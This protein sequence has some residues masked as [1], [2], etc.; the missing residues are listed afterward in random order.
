[1]FNRIDLHALA[2]MQGPERAFL[3]AYLAGPDSRKHLEHRV[4]RIEG[5][6][7]GNADEL[8]HFGESMKILR[9]FLDSTPFESE[10]MCVFACWA[11]DFL[12]AHHLEQ[13]V[14]DLL[15]I[16]AAP[17]IRPIA[18]LQDEF[19]NFVVVAAD[20]S[21]SRV[22]FV[23]SA[24]PTEDER[25][26]GDVKNRVKKGGWSQKRY[27]RRREN[28]LLHYANEVVEVLEDLEKRRRFDRIILAGSEEAMR[29][30][31]EQLPQRL[32]EKLVD[33]R[34][35]NLHD[36]ED[37]WSQ[38][39]EIFEGEERQS[40]QALWDQIYAEYMQGGRAAM[41]FDDV[42]TAAATGRAEKM[43]VTRDVRKA[44]TRCR[45]C[46]NVTP[47]ESRQCPYCKSRDVFKVD[48]VEELVRLLELS[49]GE[50]EFSDPIDGLSHVGD[51]AALLR[52]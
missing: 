8:T 2:A 12:Q 27:A 43:I 6:L 24:V 49:S 29:T 13:T 15:W 37:F 36:E 46:S 5:L 25:I 22:Y 34:A 20:N 4:A 35:L 51:V 11:N 30:I 47:R 9:D 26:K 18:E 39:F 21:E 1:M 19:E 38:I 17:Y 7:Q 33:A 10:S 50:T 23:T 42:L 3:S 28:E 41:G 48:L 32:E 45:D 52:Y 40:E 16:G 31:R 44:G 14:D